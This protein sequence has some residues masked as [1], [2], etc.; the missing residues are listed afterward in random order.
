MSEH[1]DETAEPTAPEPPA[2]PDGW[3]LW[4]ILS[5][6]LAALLLAM[7]GVVW[8]RPGLWGVRL[9]LAIP[10]LGG[11]TAIFLAWGLIRTLFN[12]PVLRRSR[13]IAFFTLLGC[14]VIG[15]VPLV[16]APLATEQ[17]VTP[18][19]YQL[20]VRGEW[21]VLAGG[22]QK[23]RNYH[24]TFPPTRWG[25]DFGLARDGALFQLDGASNED[26]YCFDQPV[27]A[28]VTGRIVTLNNH[29]VDNHPGEISPTSR[30]GNFV[31]I[32][33][34]DGEFT[35]LAHLRKGSVTVKIGDEVVVGDVIGKCGNSGQSP[36]P[37]LHMHVQDRADF[38][39]AQGLPI[40]FARLRVDG[41]L[42][43][44]VMPAGSAIWEAADGAVVQHVP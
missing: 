16:P 9:L 5:M 32:E 4:A 17:Y 28:P 38:P 8:L 42:T 20:P 2:K 14:G 37:H 22:P 31:L 11:A 34:S 26:W 15:T 7:W 19:T 10:F 3:E 44:N 12:P 25:Y 1:D 41:E 43:H 30:L 29:H 35:V 13:T 33:A 27:Y 39:L 6:V 21:T 40:A 24:A 18:N 23:A 36:G